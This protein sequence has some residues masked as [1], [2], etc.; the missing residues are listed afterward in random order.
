MSVPV[1]NKSDMPTVR[2]DIER[3]LSLA[4]TVLDNHT[5]CTFSEMIQLPVSQ[6]VDQA[7]GRDDTYQHHPLLYEPIIRL[8]NLSLSISIVPLHCKQAFIRP[9]AKIST[10]SQPTD[11]S[12]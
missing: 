1:L 7:N 6:R 5:S 12:H 11:F 9:N 3:I 2:S 8:F 4:A 10:L